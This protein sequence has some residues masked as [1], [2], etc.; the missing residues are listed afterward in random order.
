MKL[1]A[2][3]EHVYLDLDALRAHGGMEVGVSDWLEIGQA[4]IDTFADLCGDHQFIHVDPVR[5]AEANFGGTI[6]HGFY[7]LSLLTYFAQG[8]R[9]RI[10]GTRHSVN[11]GFDRVRF[12]A[13]VRPGVRIRARFRLSRI[14]ERE[15]GEITQH[16]AVTV[17]I[18]GEERPAVLA[19]WST[20]AYLGAA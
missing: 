3:R 12:V 2:T 14:E 6:A 19:E 16:Y 8:V 7:T 17:E 18:E 15:P 10:V 20:R 11:Y 9:P 1:E 5:A 4:Q 13:P